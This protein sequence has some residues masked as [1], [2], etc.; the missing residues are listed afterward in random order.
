MGGL[1]PGPPLKSGPDEIFVVC[2]K[3]VIKFSLIHH[4][5]TETEKNSEKKTK[6]KKLYSSIMVVSR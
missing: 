6:N 4:M 2:S 3:A 1:G 5:E